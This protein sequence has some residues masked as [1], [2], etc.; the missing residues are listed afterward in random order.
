MASWRR[1]LDGGHR[2]GDVDDSTARRRGRGAAEQEQLRIGRRRF[3]VLN[4]QVM[5]QEEEEPLLASQQ[6]LLTPQQELLIAA[7]KRI[8]A[9]EEAR[10]R[11]D[12]IF[13]LVAFPFLCLCLYYL[14]VIDQLY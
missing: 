4:V 6:E 3:A 1:A 14:L 13:A 10:E 7:Q 2:T 5:L 8:Q 12:K 11:R 9:D